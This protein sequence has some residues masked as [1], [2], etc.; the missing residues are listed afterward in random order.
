MSTIWFN[1]TSFRALFPAFANTTTYPDATLQIYWDTGTSYISDKYGYCWPRW[2]LARQTL[3]LNQMAAHLAYLNTQIA[4][5]KPTG[6]LQG[7]TIDKITV[8]L[9]PPPL[10]DQWS[11]WLNQSPYGQ[12]LLALLQTAAVGG[13]FAGGFPVRDSLRR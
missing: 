6:V 5:G 10:T 1:A 8:Q 12:Q 7:A 4:A 3:A 9:Q 11:W 13:F 2:P